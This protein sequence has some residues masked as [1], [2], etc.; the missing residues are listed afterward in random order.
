MACAARHDDPLLPL[1]AFF[2]GGPFFFSA[3]CPTDL[4]SP[5]LFAI[6][7]DQKFWQLSAAILPTAY[8]M[9][10]DTLVKG[11]PKDFVWTSREHDQ[12]ELYTYKL[13]V[14]WLICTIT[15]LFSMLCVVPQFCTLEQPD[16]SE[17]TICVKK[18]RVGYLMAPPLLLMIAICGACLVWQWWSV[19]DDYALFMS[20]FQRSQKE[21]VFLSEL[22]AKLLCESDDD[23]E[24]RCDRMIDRSMLNRSWMDPMLISFFVLHFFMFAGFGFVNREFEACDSPPEKLVVEANGKPAVESENLI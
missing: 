15:I 19:Q 2:K 14:M 22:E 12:L 7:I 16:G 23:K 5:I 1:P 24:G 4:A 21:E 11:E 3:G 10:N 17:L 20:L 8:K 18:K 9:F 6:A 13:T